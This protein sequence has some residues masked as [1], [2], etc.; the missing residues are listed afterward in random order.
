MQWL[1]NLFKRKSDQATP[2]R[3]SQAKVA[4]EKGSVAGFPPQRSIAGAQHQDDSDNLPLSMAISSATGNVA[5][6]YIAG[7]SMTGAILGSALGSDSHSDASAAV[8]IASDR[9]DSDLA[10]SSSS[11]E[12]GS[13]SDSD[14][15]HGSWD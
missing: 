1:K 7:G 2:N 5:L 8:C 9:G 4:P 6:G 10:S 3:E 12:S 15:S 14:S 11:C 13:S